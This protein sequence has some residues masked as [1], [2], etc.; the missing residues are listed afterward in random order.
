MSN[1]FQWVDFYQ[2]LA[3][4]LL[5]YKDDRTALIEKVKAVYANTQIC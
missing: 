3:D 5:T 1:Q 4:I 2:E